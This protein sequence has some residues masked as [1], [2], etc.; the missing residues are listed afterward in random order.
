LLCCCVVVKMK[1]WKDEDVKMSRCEDVRMLGW[2]DVKFWRC[3]MK[4]WRCEDVWQTPTIRRTLRSD[5]REK[6]RVFSIQTAWFWWLWMRVGP[7]MLKFLIFFLWQKTSHLMLL[8]VSAYFFEEGQSFDQHPSSQDKLG[9]CGG[10]TPY[11]F[12]S[13]SKMLSISQRIKIHKHT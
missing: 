3:D 10:W 8:G 9:H 11:C 6:R 12:G 2:E 13:F 5:S 7:Y 4:M 1:R